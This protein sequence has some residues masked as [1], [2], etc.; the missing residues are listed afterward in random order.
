M[1]KLLLTVFMALS[2]MLAAAQT[3]IQVQMHNVVALDEQFNVTFVIEGDKPSEFSWEPGQ[4]FLLVWG[5][6]QGRS[7]SMQIINGKRTSSSQTTY[8]YILKPLKVG[9]FTIPKASAV[10]KGKNIYSAEQSIEVVSQGSSS[11]QQQSSSSAQQPAQRK[12]QTGMISDSDLFMKLSLSRND[13]VVGEP[14]IATIK[15]YQRVNITG[16]ESASFPS[17]NGFWGQEVETPTN[18]EFSRETYEGQIYNAAVLRKFVLI[19][20]QKGQLKIDPAELVCLVNIRVSSGGSS[21]FDGFFDDYRTVRKKVMSAPTTVNVKPLPSGAPASFAGG[22][23]EFSI[24][25]T[26]SKDSLKAHEAA[27]LV[28]T[29]SG[30]GNVSLLETPK[31]SFPPDME[32]YDTKVVSNVAAN[33]LSGSKKY[34]YPFIPRSHGDFVIE[35]IKY[36]YYDVNQKKYVTLET[37]PIE[38]SVAKGVETESSPV[39]VPGVN[40]KDVRNLDSDIRYINVKDPS[41]SVKGDFLLGSGLFW[42]LVCLLVAAAAILWLA[43]RKLA[44][45]RADIA[46][47]KNRKATKMAMKRLRLAGTFLKE[48]LYTAFYEELHKALLGFIADKLNIP[49]A[50]LSRDRIA[51][52]L[53]AGNVPQEDVDT[54]INILDACEFARYSPS[55]GNE[56]MAAHYSSAA[57]VISSIDSS[58]KSKRNVTQVTAILLL[59][60]LMPSVGYAAEDTY[61]DSLWNAANEAYAQAQWEAAIADY[62]MISTMGLESAPLYCNIGNAYYKS[63]NI[64]MAVLYYERA[65]K[66]DPSYA[67]AEHNL[68]LVNN[69][70]QD[71]IDPVPE[72]FLRKWMKDISYVMDSDSW[73]VIFLILLALTL[74]LFLLFLLAPSAAGRRAGF[75]VGLVTFVL[76]FFCIVRHSYAREQD[77]EELY[78]NGHAMHILHSCIQDLHSH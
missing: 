36:S 54:F 35:P 38:L 77:M 3:D 5:P 23:G 46:G 26:V 75:F 41:L 51:E 62:E 11:S 22:V 17:F 16:F 32:V 21:I 13:V 29:V 6:Q 12:E 70:I 25:A 20:Q 45:R 4:D 40:Q 7:T 60:M 15:L 44:A 63:A 14:I 74:A 50:E 69:L 72:F 67:D 37:A 2:A 78:H 18:I 52:S 57:E 30:R 59:L 64:P 10:V 73:A 31:V 76:M 27:A 49:V 34:E 53:R 56:A 71:R 61:V 43:L 8:S 33:G 1:R 28:V 66:L 47:A 68:A 48:N 55:T 9:K 39:V 58:M 19:P 42:A 65:L 24:S